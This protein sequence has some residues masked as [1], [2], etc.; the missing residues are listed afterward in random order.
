WILIK[1]NMWLYSKYCNIMEEWNDGRV[2]QWNVGN[3]LW[4]IREMRS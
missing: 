3:C 4:F 1:M 2:E